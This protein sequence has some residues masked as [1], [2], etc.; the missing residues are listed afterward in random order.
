[1]GAFFWSMRLH[2]LQESNTG[3]F[4]GHCGSFPIGSS[5]CGA[6][7]GLRS[8]LIGVC[9]LAVHSEA[10]KGSRRIT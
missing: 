4:T 5:P 10:V 8:F 2:S 6:F 1:M 3:V 9:G 7:I